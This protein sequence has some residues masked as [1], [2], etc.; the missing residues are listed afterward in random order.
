MRNKVCDYM[1]VINNQNVLVNK[2]FVHISAGMYGTVV[3]RFHA[4]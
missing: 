1:F 4:V 3:T 2:I